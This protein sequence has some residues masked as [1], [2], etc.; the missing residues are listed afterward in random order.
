MRERRYRIRLKNR[1]NKKT[2]TI[3]PKLNDDK[4]GLLQFPIDLMEWKILSIDDYIGLDDSC[5][6]KVYENNIVRAYGFNPEYY[7][8]KFIE[9][10]FCLHR[11]D[12]K[13]S[14]IDINMMYPYNG[15]QME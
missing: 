10:G 14:P 9:G 8:I 7:Q 13:G 11:D 4:G 15:G 3:Y 6:E 2:L 5:G 12:L 1:S